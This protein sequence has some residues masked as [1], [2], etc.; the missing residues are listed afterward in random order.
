MEEFFIGALRVLGTLIRWLMIELL[1]DRVVY[2]VGYAGL[3]ILT[4][5]KRPRR[6]VSQEM[7]R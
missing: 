3:Y 2:S 6:P 1:L 5:G 7:K 4:L